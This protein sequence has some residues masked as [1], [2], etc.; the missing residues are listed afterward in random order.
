[1]TRRLPPFL[2]LLLLL[3]MLGQSALVLVRAS[4]EYAQQD[5]L[6]RLVQIDLCS[7]NLAQSAPDTLPAPCEHCLTQ[8][9]AA[10]LTPSPP[11]LESLRLAAWPVA[12]L[13]FS[14]T[15]HPLSS[16][17]RPQVRAPPALA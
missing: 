9:C 12:P 1:M 2:A 15:R 4:A 3:A 5:G 11:A 8:C 16:W 6:A 7:H 10:F 17:Q 13:T 14:S